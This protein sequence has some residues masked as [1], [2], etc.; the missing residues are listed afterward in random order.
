LEE[1]NQNRPSLDIIILGRVLKRLY[2]VLLLILGCKE[3]AHSSIKWNLVTIT[4]WYELSIKDLNTG[5]DFLRETSCLGL[6][7]R[8]QAIKGTLESIVKETGEPYK[9]QEEYILEKEK[10]RSFDLEGNLNLYFDKIDLF[11]G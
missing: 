9:L 8:S 1:A 7:C 6:L 11:R 4:K 10:R 3:Q 5:K 2:D